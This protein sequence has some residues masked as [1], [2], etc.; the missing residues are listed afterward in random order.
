MKNWKWFLVL[1]GVV[2]AVGLGWLVQQRGVAESKGAHIDRGLPVVEIALNGVSLGEIEG[3]DKEVKYPGNQLSLHDGDGVQEYDNVEIKGRGNTTWNIP[4]RPYQIKFSQKV[5]FLGL[6]K[7]KKWVLLAN[8]LDTSQLRTDVAFDVAEMLGAESAAR[9]EFVDL[10]IDGDYRGLYYV[11]QKVE[12]DK[13]RVDLRDPL[14][15]LVELDNLH[16]DL[17]EHCYRTANEACLVAKDLVNDEMEGAAMQ[18][19]L[20]D[21]DRLE[22]AAAEGDYETVA[23]LVDIESFAKYFL[24]SEF[25]VNPDAYS[26]SFYM[27]KDGA[28]DKIHAGPGWDFDYALGNKAWR[29]G[30]TDEFYSPSANMI[31]EIDVMGGE[32]VL[33]G[34]VLEKAPDMATSRVLYYMMRMPEFRAEVERIYQ[35]RMQGRKEELLWRIWRRAKKIASAVEADETK[36]GRE[37]FWEGAE[38]ERGG[39]WDEVKYLLEWVEVRYEHFEK[40]YGR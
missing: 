8:F 27:Y 24:L 20:V 4:K 17:D 13:E 39:F 30:L 38:W 36:W 19:F 22:L 3:G 33:N 34:E 15:V 28:E 9:G 40:E 10:Y 37:E 6:G 7:A 35:E 21:F 12:I 14:G 1:V 11:T 5:D 29:W 26:T 16:V 2:F 32:F 23:E 31:R 18:G 25:T